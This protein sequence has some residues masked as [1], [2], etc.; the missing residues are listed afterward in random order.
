MNIELKEVTSKE[1]FEEFKKNN[2]DFFNVASKDIPP[3]KGLVQIMD[4]T[5]E[6]VKKKICDNYCKYP[7]IWDAEKEGCEL[8]ESRICGECPLNNL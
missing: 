2:P 8:W 7:A 3:V 4:D 5:L 1:D 6:E